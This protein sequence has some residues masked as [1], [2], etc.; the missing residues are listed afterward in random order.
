MST[1]PQ[2]AP[3]PVPYL[4]LND[5]VVRSEDRGAVKLLKGTVILI[6]KIKKYQ[7]YLLLQIREPLVGKF[8]ILFLF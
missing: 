4:L 2:R 3:E 6:S 7:N 1:E 8:C 5:M